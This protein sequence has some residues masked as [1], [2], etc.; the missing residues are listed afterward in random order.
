[1][2]I[3]LRSG[4]FLL[5]A[6][7]L[8]PQCS[9]S[10]APKRRTGNDLLEMC[11]YVDKPVSDQPVGEKALTLSCLS[12]TS[13]FMDGVLAGSIAASKN[14]Q[15]LVCPSEEVTPQQVASVILKYLREHPEDGHE[16]ALG[17][18]YVA[19]AHVFP[20]KPAP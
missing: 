5:A 13:G 8:I 6:G 11:Q 7:L 15:P 20:C 2:R 18:A 17:L 3:K 19:L 10:S 16:D 14:G 1:M 9:S 12:Y 4:A